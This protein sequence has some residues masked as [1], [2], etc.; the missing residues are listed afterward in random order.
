LSSLKGYL[1]NVFLK[2]K[3]KGLVLGPGC[4]VSQVN[5]GENV[6]LGN[7]VTALSSDIRDYSYIGNNAVVSNASIGKFCSIAS[8]VH[9]GVG[10]HP[11]SVWVSTHP[12]FYLSRPGMGWDLIES[13]I[14][15][16]SARTMIGSDVW[17]GTRATIKDGVR[18]SDGAIIGAGAVVTKDLDSYG[19]YVGIPAKLIR[20]RFEPDEIAF[21]K[22]LRWWDKDLSWIR[23]NA[24]AFR[25]V[26]LLMG[27]K[28]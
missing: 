21:L 18:I 22:S 1:K 13:D 28:R 4:V 16:E 5:F 17:V 8:E 24:D 19:I 20:Y 6:R 2:L 23:Q 3:N 11:S 15:P 9:V 12:F 27:R 14:R 10:S 7:T 25:D 26:D